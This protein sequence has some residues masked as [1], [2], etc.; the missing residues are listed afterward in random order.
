METYRG[1]E[2]V[3]YPDMSPYRGRAGAARVE[4]SATTRRVCQPQCSSQQQEV[5]R[6]HERPDSEVVGA[7]ARLSGHR[8]AVGD[9]AGAGSFTNTQRMLQWHHQAVEPD[10]DARSD[11]WFTFHLGRIIRE[12]LASSTDEMDRPILNLTWDYPTK[13]SPARPEIAEPEA[14]AV[15]AE[16]N[17][18]DT[19]SGPLSSY[20]QLNED[21]STVCGC[22]I[23]CGVY[24]DGINQAAR[25]KPGIEQ[26]WVAK[27]WGWAW[28]A[29][30]R[31]LYNR[32]SADPDGKP[33]SERK[34]LVWW[35]E[36]KALWTGHDTPDFSATKSRHYRPPTN[37]TGAEALAGID[38][39]VMQADGKSWLFVPAGLTDGPL[40]THYAAAPRRVALPLGQQR[41]GHRRPGQ[42]ADPPVARPQRAHPRG[43]ALACDIQPGR[44]PRP[45]PRRA[46]QAVPGTGRDHRAD[47]DG[48]V[49][50]PR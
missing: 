47:R 5:A 8:A 26:N 21:G 30:R 15:L 25:R 2:T 17:G 33:W 12:K 9:A 13:S 45:G 39:F 23:Y 38:P 29:N 16:I 3:K 28:P 19:E 31:I 50:W 14:E 11:L 46:R 44:R 10:G 37:A 4:V 35:D 32:A 18:W 48:G 6:A 7:G 43:E 1:N 22:W 34:A 40:P 36:D 41:P 49:R 20:E 24:S 42:R 27:E